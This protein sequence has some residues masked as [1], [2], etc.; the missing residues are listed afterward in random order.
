M[1]RH[2]LPDFV[3][4]IHKELL[5]R[6][7]MDPLHYDRISDK[8]CQIRA[9]IDNNMRPRTPKGRTIKELYLAQVCDLLLL[10]DEIAKKDEN[11][12]L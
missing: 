4:Y 12:M 10:N 9:M 6:N 2:S 11:R 8:L 3:R 1:N 5:L 7:T